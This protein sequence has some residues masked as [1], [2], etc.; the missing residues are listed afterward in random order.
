MHFARHPWS[1]E[2]TTRGRRH[3]PHGHG[4]EKPSMDV[5]VLA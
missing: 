5:L 4:K 2:H 1:S 3:G